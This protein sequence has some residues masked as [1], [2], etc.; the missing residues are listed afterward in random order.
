MNTKKDEKEREK[1]GNL[2]KKRGKTQGTT[3]ARIPLKHQKSWA[4]KGVAD[5]EP[6]VYLGLKIIYFWL[7]SRSHSTQSSIDDVRWRLRT[8]W[9]KAI[10]KKTNFFTGG[11]EKWI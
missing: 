6:L 5:R 3:E 8:W 4:L 2:G 7:V 10:E 9:Y 1:K 11:L